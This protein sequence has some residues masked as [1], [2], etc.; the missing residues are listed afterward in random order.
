[1]SVSSCNQNIDTESSDTFHKKVDKNLHKCAIIPTLS[2]TVQNETSRPGC[3]KSSTSKN[4]STKTSKNSL[5]PATLETIPKEPEVLTVD[6]IEITY[7]LT[8]KNNDCYIQKGDNKW[9]K[10]LKLSALVIA[11]ILFGVVAETRTAFSCFLSNKNA[12]DTSAQDQRDC[13][14]FFVHFVVVLLITAAQLMVLVPMYVWPIVFT[15]VRVSSAIVF[16]N[17][18]I[19]SFF[20]KEAQCVMRPISQT[21]FLY[22]VRTVFALGS[23][24]YCLRIRP[25]M[26]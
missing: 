22:S 8:N 10:I 1:M 12:D 7:D 24:C 11:T 6:N 20:S 14:A 17:S 5:L 15:F 26:K 23:L 13:S 16:L 4:L 2:V 3:S 18:C 19:N 21:F 25:A 9:S